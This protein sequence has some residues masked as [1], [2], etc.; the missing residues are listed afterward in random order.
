MT[1]GYILAMP[2]TSH[3]RPITIA[4]RPKGPLYP[5]KR[6]Y[7]YLAHA[8][9]VVSIVS[10]YPFVLYLDCD[11]ALLL[12][13]GCKGEM[14]TLPLLLLLHTITLPTNVFWSPCNFL[15]VLHIKHHSKRILW[16]SW[17]THLSLWNGGSQCSMPANGRDNSNPRLILPQSMQS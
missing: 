4:L 14:L 15:L 11:L 2:M 9:P 8:P 10:L 5:S 13:R 6:A 17:A 12:F 3:P 16:S 1:T 7:I